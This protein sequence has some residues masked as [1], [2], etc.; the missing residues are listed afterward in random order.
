MVKFSA[1][2]YPAMRYGSIV[3]TSQKAM[4]KILFKENKKL[5]N[6]LEKMRTTFFDA[7]K[8]SRSVFSNTT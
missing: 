4:K 1:V 7:T 5:R 3:M 2:V 6:F 8:E